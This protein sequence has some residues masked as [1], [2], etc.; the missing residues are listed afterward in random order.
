MTEAGIKALAEEFYAIKGSIS[1]KMNLATMSTDRS[2]SGLL[3]SMTRVCDEAGL[4]CPH[5]NSPDEK[6][7]MIYV[8][9]PDKPPEFSY[10]AP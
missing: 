10:K 5:F 8:L 9:S 3:T 4:D 6:G 1:K 7:L 2:A